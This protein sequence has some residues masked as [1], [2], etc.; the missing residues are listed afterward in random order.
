LIG[1]RSDQVNWLVSRSNSLKQFDFR[2]LIW[3]FLRSILDSFTDDFKASDNCTLQD[4]V[5]QEA[6]EVDIGEVLG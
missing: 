4:W 1:L 5:V 3:Q 6:F 2:I